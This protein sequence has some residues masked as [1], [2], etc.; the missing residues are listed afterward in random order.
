M[1]GSFQKTFLLGIIRE[2]FLFEH[3]GTEHQ[4]KHIGNDCCDMYEI[5]ISRYEQFV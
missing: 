4:I 1:K 2:W 5:L 3:L